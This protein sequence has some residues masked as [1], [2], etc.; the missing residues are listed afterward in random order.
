MAN[1]AKPV[2]RINAIDT[3]PGHPTGAVEIRKPVAFLDPATAETFRQHIGGARIIDVV[4]STARLALTTE[5]VHARDIVREVGRVEIATITCPASTYTA[6]TTGFVYFDAVACVISDTGT[7]ATPDETMYFGHDEQGGDA[8][9]TGLSLADGSYTAEQM[10]TAWAAFIDSN[11]AWLNAAAVGDRVTITFVDQVPGAYVS[12]LNSAI[13]SYGGTPGAYGTHSADTE[14]VFASQSR[15]VGPAGHIV[16]PA[17]DQTAAQVAAL[18]AAGFHALSGI[19]ATVTDAVVTL[20]ADSPSEHD[21]AYDTNGHY[22][23]ATTQD[24]VNP[25]RMYIFVG[26][27]AADTANWKELVSSTNGMG[28]YCR[29]GIQNN[30]LSTSPVPRNAHTLL[31]MTRL[32]RK[33]GTTVEQDGSGRI[34]VLQTGLYF[35]SAALYTYPSNWAGVQPTDFAFHSWINNN[36]YNS[37]RW[38]NT[39]GMSTTGTTGAAVV[40]MEANQY[41]DLR[42][43]A[44]HP[45]T[46]FTATPRQIWTEFYGYNTLMVQRIG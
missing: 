29:V 19:T 3:P 46:N 22:T 26:T 20:T 37:V 11:Y 5:Q 13:S 15:T 32:M 34:R 33:V 28:D 23:L 30:S 10:A 12:S 38:L 8:Y 24:G 41:I 21:D 6:G 1:P 25:G 17:S 18:V 2:T 14:I 35:V 31:P 16:L 39:T 45:T 36:E 40:Y 4:D 27:D 7:T 44:Y 43:H 9:A 42:Y